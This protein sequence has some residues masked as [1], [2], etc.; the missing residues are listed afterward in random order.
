[1]HH[2]QAVSTD[3]QHNRQ[4][5]QASC[6]GVGVSETPATHGGNA[7]GNADATHRDTDMQEGGVLEADSVP[8]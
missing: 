2:L 6:T 3:A 5:L 8:E 1:M 7:G 4:S